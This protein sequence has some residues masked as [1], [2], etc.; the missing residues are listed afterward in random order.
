LT[1]AA[2]SGVN[3]EE[4]GK[5]EEKRLRQRHSASALSHTDTAAAVDVLLNNVTGDDMLPL[6][7]IKCRRVYSVHVTAR[8]ELCVL[9]FFTG[10]N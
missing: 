1:D 10:V 9:D 8:K 6:C 3:C 7:V 4:D 2:H 5:E